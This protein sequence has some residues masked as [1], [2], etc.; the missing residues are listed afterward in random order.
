MPEVAKQYK[1]MSTQYQSNRENYNIIEQK[2][3]AGGF[4]K[5]WKKTK[6]GN[7]SR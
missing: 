2:L 4:P 7:P 3:L 6:K 1:E 5:A